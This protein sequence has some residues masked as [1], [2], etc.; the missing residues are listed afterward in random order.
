MKEKS[1]NAAANPSIATKKR[2]PYR[3]YLKSILFLAAI[4]TLI[5][6]QVINERPEG[7]IIEEESIYKQDVSNTETRDRQIV[8]PSIVYSGIRIIF[9]PS[10]LLWK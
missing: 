7:K 10:H 4:Y 6:N 1:T 8:L 2:I 5:I 9:Y 3:E